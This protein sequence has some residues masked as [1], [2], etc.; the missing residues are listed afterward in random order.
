MR[1]RH[2]LPLASLALAAACAP[3]TRQV[4]TL[5]AP[6]GEALRVTAVGPLTV[7]VEAPSPVHLH[8]LELHP[9]T[10]AV[11]I[12]VDLPLEGQAVEGRARIALRGA[13]P[14]AS[15]LSSQYCTAPGERLVYATRDARGQSRIPQAGSGMLT[16]HLTRR[17][18]GRAGR[19]AYCV[20]S[21][22]TEMNAH[23]TPA[24]RH[25]LLV[26]VPRA[27]EVEE[28]ARRVEA[29]NERYTGA[30]LPMDEL[31]AEV[32]AT[33]PRDAVSTVLHVVVPRR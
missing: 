26:V 29:L 2:A 22:E 33:F 17:V 31:A 10:G 13:G 30:P 28:L 11:G 5:V 18:V 8:V 7:Q 21:M 27:M 19:E 4:T 6:V 16:G 32:A 20:R 1:L 9:S 3:G 23:A 25:L 24:P 14:Q 12:P 15:H